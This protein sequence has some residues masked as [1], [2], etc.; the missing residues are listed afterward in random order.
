[1]TRPASRACNRSACRHLCA[2]CYL[3]LFLWSPVSACIDLVL[4]QH[5]AVT[6]QVLDRCI[7]GRVVSAHA[8]YI[9]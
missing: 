9:W 5:S 1:M 4:G 7:Y 2:P 6:E 3:T 8:H